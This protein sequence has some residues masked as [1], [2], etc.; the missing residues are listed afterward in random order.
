[1]EIYLITI[2]LLIFFGIFDIVKFKR[3]DKVILF[4]IIF[5]IFVLLDGLRW[6][7]GIDWDPYRYFFEKHPEYRTISWEPG[8]V[9]F[10]D[11]FYLVSQNYSLFLFASA[12]L[13]YSI[14]LR[15]IYQYTKYPLIAVLC[16]NSVVLG[17]MGMNRQLIAVA[18]CLFAFRYIVSRESYKFFFCIIIA[19]LFHYSSILFIL[20]YFLNR[21]ISGSFLVVLFFSAIA[22]HPVVIYITDFILSTLPPQ[23]KYSI[24]MKIGFLSYVGK[25]MIEETLTP[26]H[27]TPIIFLGIVKRLIIFLPLFFNRYKL[28]QKFPNIELM[29]NI[30][31]V[32]IL[33]Y[34]LF[35]NNFQILVSKG[36]LYFGL[37]EMFL[38]PFYFELFKKNNYLLVY[39][40]I[41]IY[42]SITYSRYLYFTSWVLV[43]YNSIIYDTGIVKGNIT[44]F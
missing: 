15:S 10:N 20:A 24:S 28:K 19:A 16:F 43:P 2:L 13:I 44:R 7:T 8:Y 22:L 11:L 37:F 41:I 31:F 36:A 17:Y 12:I 25:K 42:V 9:L 27:P 29:L 14:F 21:H 4:V 39:S 23:I 33:F 26:V 1:M 5:I 40:V 35:N 38:L 6:E 3:K 34:I 32:S 30:Y 18:I